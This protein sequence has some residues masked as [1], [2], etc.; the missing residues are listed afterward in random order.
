MK[1]YHGTS[2]TNLLKILAQGALIPRGET[3][4]GNWAHSVSSSPNHVYLTDSYAPYSS[5]QA[6]KLDK[7]GNTDDSCVVIELDSDLLDICN[8]V[9]DEDALE[10]ANGGRMMSKGPWSKGP[11]GTGRGSTNGRM[12]TTEGAFR[13]ELEK[14]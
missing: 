9:P 7:Q 10:Q 11:C 5:F 12:G 2:R 8:M 13:R 1:L 4:N 6:L 14:R 3:K